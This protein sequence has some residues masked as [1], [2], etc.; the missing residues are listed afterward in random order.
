MDAY[1]T[2]WIAYLAAAI[3]AFSLM[4][5][6][7]ESAEPQA[8]VTNA[9]PTGPRLEIG[10]WNIE[11]VRLG[12][13][14]PLFILSDSATGAVS[15]RAILAKGGFKPVAPETPP[16]VNLDPKAAGR[17]EISVVPGK[18]GSAILRLDTVTGRVWTHQLSAR[19]KSW[20]EVSNAAASKP[21]ETAKAGPGGSKMVVP[22]QEPQK[23]PIGPLLEVVNDPEMDQ[24]FRVWTGGLL[25][26][27]YP[28]K[29]LDL[30]STKI[31]SSDPELMVGMIGELDLSQDPSLRSR[32]APFAKNP[33]ASVASA[34]KK[35]LA[36][37][38]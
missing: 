18:G 23:I 37:T 22:A 7:S 38:K 10:R 3:A 14:R 28:S 20:V 25:A 34:A 31:V 26:E 35:K 32:L 4:V 24:S 19:K 8:A 17:F 11:A 36:A 12:V 27:A 33:N 15:A 6:C 30:L 9:G 2:T 21:V 29:T 5:G 1:K 16:G 13:N